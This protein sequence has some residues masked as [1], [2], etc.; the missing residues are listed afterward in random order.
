[1][2]LIT[3]HERFDQ[4]QLDAWRKGRRQELIQL[5]GSDHLR[6]VLKLKASSWKRPTARFF[7]ESYVASCNS[8]CS[9][10]YGSF[11]WLTNA[12]FANAKE[13]SR[14]PARPFQQALREA[15]HKHFTAAGV[16]EVQRAALALH[17]TQS[18]ALQGKKPTAPDL[19][20][21]DE[22]DHHRFIEAKLP[23][24]S[25]APHQVVGLAVIGACFGRRR[26]VSVEIVELRP[27]YE[28][29]FERFTKSVTAG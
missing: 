5:A 22:H 10:F 1:M 14:G 3:S 19:W 2:E 11:K 26:S 24:D 17:R 7:G 4:A 25:L 13:F 21:L 23:G 18:S 20:L 6:G 28:E 9:G 16:Q 15:L 8:G 27:R 12:K 29:L